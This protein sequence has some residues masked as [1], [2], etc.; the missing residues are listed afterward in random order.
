MPRKWG[1]QFIENLLN[2]MHKKWIFRHSRVHYRGLDGLTAAQHEA[3]FEQV[4][5][6]MYTKPDNLLPKHRHLI[7]Q[8]FEGLTEG[9]AVE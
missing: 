8:D 3:I 4:E 6:M 7:E 1:T 2:I 5:E 9:S